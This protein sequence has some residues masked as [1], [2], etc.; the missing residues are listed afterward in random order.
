[1]PCE[2]LLQF[3]VEAVSS[4]LTNRYTMLQYI[5]QQ[6]YES[7]KQ[8]YNASFPEYFS[9]G[10]DEFKLRRNDLTKLFIAAGY[11]DL[12]TSSYRRTLSASTAAAYATCMAQHSNQLIAAWIQ[13]Y[14][15]DK[16]LVSIRNGRTED[17]SYTVIG[18]TPQPAE[19]TSTLGGGGDKVLEFDY[20]PAQDFLVAFNAVGLKTGQMGSTIVVLERER[21]FEIRKTQK[22]LISKLS[23]GAGGYGHG[24]GN[25]RWTDTTFVAEQDYYL[26]FDTRRVVHEE[27]IGSSPGLRTYQLEWIPDSPTR[28]RRVAVHPYGMVGNS[29]DTQG[30]VELTLSIM[31]ER[32]ELIEVTP[33]KAVATTPLGIAA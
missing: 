25:Y 12:H 29:N 9:G 28:T 4:S 30:I 1:M 24:D 3:D 6:N 2:D 20:D 16:I 5:N 33:T 8:E 11:S 7:M 21:R 23:C 22:E 18:A 19:P 31:A 14:S 27:A 17:V 26:L 32:E 15:G 10:Y 13:T